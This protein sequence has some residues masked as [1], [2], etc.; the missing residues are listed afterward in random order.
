MSSPVPS[1]AGR[2]LARLQRVTWSKVRRHLKRTLHH[3]VEERIYRVSVSEAMEF[4]EHPLFQ[5]DSLD[6]LRRYV[7]APDESLPDLLSRWEKRLRSGEHVYTRTE[8][9]RLAAYGWLVERQQVCFLSEVHQQG[10]FPPDT[11]V[12]YDFFVPPE[13]RSR[14]FYPQL[15]M[16]SLR[17]AA[18]TIPG[19]RWIY[20][21]LRADDTVPRWWVERLGAHYCESYFY[22]RKLWREKKWYRDCEAGTGESK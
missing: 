11:A 15:L 17:H 5:F 6:D 12:L 8:Q 14:D 19:T 9:G 18:G 4:D 7:P 20:M 10:T 2:L 13:F 16:H 1:A 22:E 3:R 21:A